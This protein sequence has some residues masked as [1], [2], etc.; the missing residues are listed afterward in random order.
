MPQGTVGRRHRLPKVAVASFPAMS[1][2][3]TREGPR[4]AGRIDNDRTAPEYSVV[5]C[6]GMDC[7]QLDSAFVHRCATASTQSEASTDIGRAW[8][9]RRTRFASRFAAGTARPR[10]AGDR[11]FLAW[12]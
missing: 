1:V 4:P 3:T 7:W 12:L 9:W 11:D 6:R 5:P 10:Q 2:A 8:T